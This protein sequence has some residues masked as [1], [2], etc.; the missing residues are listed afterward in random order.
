MPATRQTPVISRPDATAVRS[1]RQ[2]AAF[3]AARPRQK[4]GFM[5]EH[6]G[7]RVDLDFYGGRHREIEA[8]TRVLQGSRQLPATFRVAPWEVQKVWLGFMPGGGDV[9][10]S[11]GGL[12]LGRRTSPEVQAD[13]RGRGAFGEIGEGE[14]P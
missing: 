9:R 3:S 4:Y 7:V 6:A 8:R 1:S 5:R 2:A 12:R 11:Y 13:A 14:G 10:G